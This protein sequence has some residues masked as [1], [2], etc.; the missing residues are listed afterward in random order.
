MKSSITIFRATAHTFSTFVLRKFNIFQLK[1]IS[2]RLMV[3]LEE[4]ELL[5]FT[6]NL[7]NSLRLPDSVLQPFLH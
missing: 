4:Y 5:G 1:N 7:Q 2:K 6:S 3:E